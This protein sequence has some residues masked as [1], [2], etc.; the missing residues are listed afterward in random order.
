MALRPDFVSGFAGMQ[1]IG[2]H[3]FGNRAVA[4]DQL[5]SRNRCRKCF[6]RHPVWRALVHLQDFSALRAERLAAR[7]D[8]E[9]DDFCVRL[10]GAD[11][12]DDG[13]HAFQNFGLGVVLVVGIVGADHHDGDFGLDAVELAVLKTPEDVLGA[14]AADAHVD[15]LAPTVKFL[16]HIFARAFPDFRDG[17]ADEFDVVIAGIFLGALQHEGLAVGCP[18]GARH[19]NDRGVLV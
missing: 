19:G 17:V 7:E 5:R 14:V 9:Q 8:A 6:C 2:H 12:V 13:G 18:V 3:V 1:I 4:L 16:P 15:G 11:L 10:A